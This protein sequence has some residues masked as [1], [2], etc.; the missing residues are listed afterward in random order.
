MLANDQRRLLGE[1]LRTHRERVRLAAPAG[2]RRTPGLRREELAARAGISAT[3]CAWLE[4][5]RSVQASPA[6]LS[7]LAQALALSGAE[8]AYLFELA[9]RLDPELPL[10]AECH[11]PPSLLAAVNAAPHPAYGL[12]RLW[13]ACCWNQP[14][15][16][17]FCGWLDGDNQRNLLRFVFLE[18]P[19][20]R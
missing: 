11:A 9:G 7:R 14:A 19:R 20:A 3:W 2:R 13:T 8:R 17:L 16:A 4:Q 5:G 12:D 10:V 1:F 15:E 18:R 6:T